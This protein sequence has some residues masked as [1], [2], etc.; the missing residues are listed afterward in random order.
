MRGRDAWG[1]KNRE[2]QLKE[3]EI[4]KRKRKEAFFFKKKKEK[5][6]VPDFWK[7]EKSGAMG[8]SNDGKK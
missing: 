6:L 5:N 7:I 2:P 3:S 4:E 1:K 8:K